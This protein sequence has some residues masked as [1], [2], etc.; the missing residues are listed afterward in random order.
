MKGLAQKC[1]CNCQKAALWLLTCSVAM[2][3]EPRKGGL[4]KAGGTP[5][6][7][8]GEGRLVKKAVHQ[9]PGHYTPVMAICINSIT[10]AY[11]C[12]SI[13]LYSVSMCMHCRQ[14]HTCM[15]I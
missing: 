9:E 3:N 8:A 4:R 2:E 1:T 12:I 7:W 11:M 14:A 15:K 6:V 5:A 10:P 13:H